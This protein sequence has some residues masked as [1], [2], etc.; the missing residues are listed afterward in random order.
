VRA[1]RRHPT[2]TKTLAGCKKRGTRA[3]TRKLP[4]GVDGLAT[5]TTRLTDD[6]PH[7][8][9]LFAALLSTGFHAL[10]RLGELVWPDVVRLQSYRKI[11]LRRSLTWARDSYSLSLPTH[12][13]SRV[14]TGHLLLVADTYQDVAACDLMRRYVLSRDALFFHAPELWLRQSGQI[15]TRSWFLH[16][17][18]LVFPDPG[19]SGH[20]MRAGGATALAL[21]GVAP[22]LIQA[23]GR[24]SS[25]E[26]QK[27]VRKHPFLQQALIHGTGPARV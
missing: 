20:S 27:Y 8:D 16:C 5:V 7:D 6:S 13:A 1:I 11:I 24:W 4:L 15:P 14:G 2:V 12:K 22:Y 3:V 26:W 19:I 9:L 10:L 25:D 17:L 18:R 21:R 23:S